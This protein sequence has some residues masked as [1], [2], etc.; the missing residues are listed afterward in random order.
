[1]YLW[2]W[3]KCDFVQFQKFLSLPKFCH[4]Y[5]LLDFAKSV[6]MSTCRF[7]SQT[8]ICRRF[9]PTEFAPN[10]LT[11]SIQILVCQ[12]TVMYLPK[13]GKY[14]FVQ[15]QKFLSLP[16]FCHSYKLHDFAKSVDMLTCRFVSQTEICRRFPPTEFAP[17]LS[18]Y[19]IQILV[20]WDAV[21]REVSVNNVPVGAI[22]HW[23]PSTYYWCPNNHHNP[24]EAT[25]LH[26]PPDAMGFSHFS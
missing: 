11:Y 13:R 19:S 24:F 16:E 1:M 5:E 15:F 8:E 4:S 3:G 26:L 21:I 6:D 14:D 17:N 18:T 9:L 20:C 22:P 25:W 23:P 10:L 12:D 2:K 7:V